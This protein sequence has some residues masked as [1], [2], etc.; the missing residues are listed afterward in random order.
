VSAFS[1]AYEANAAN[2]QCVS[3]GLEVVGAS[4]DQSEADKCAYEA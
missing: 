1:N 4:I 3:N 2:S